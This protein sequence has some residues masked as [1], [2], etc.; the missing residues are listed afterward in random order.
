MPWVPHSLPPCPSPGCTTDH[1]KT[2][3]LQTI[4]IYYLTASVS[5]EFES[6]LAGGYW[7]G[8]VPQVVDIDRDASHMKT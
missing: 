2:W 4:N 6:G 8:G 3:W 7:L 5:Q 1:P